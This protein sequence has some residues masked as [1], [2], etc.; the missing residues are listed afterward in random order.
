[1]TSNA[2]IGITGIAAALLAILVY[3]KTSSSERAVLKKDEFQ[4]FPLI[5]KIVVSHD[6]AL[7][8]F[9]LP[10]PTDVLGL[11]IGQ[12]I[13]I[14]AEI[15]GKNVI[16]SYTP[17]SLDSD[18]KGFFDLLIKIYPNGKLSNYINNLKLG[19]TIKV[20]GPKG[21]YKYEPN[22]IKNLAMVAG[23]TGI[24]PMYQ[25]IKAVLSNP[26]DKTKITLLYGSQTESDILLRAELDELALKHDNF[27]L[28]HFLDKAPENWGGK[29]G[30]INKDALQEFFPKPNDDVQLLLCG[31]PGLVSSIKRASLE[32]GFEK[33]K[34]VSKQGD[35]VFLF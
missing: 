10:R 9:G 5:Q 6:S 12:H 1:M 29:I 30:Y 25:I 23:G 11:P 13:Q 33:A 20:K 7:F 3:L 27:K 8:R 19:E 4:E 26:N 28:I 16:H 17:T 21:F 15:D 14:S 32:L 35:Q 22:N 18:S 31:P 2:F 24:T 34:P